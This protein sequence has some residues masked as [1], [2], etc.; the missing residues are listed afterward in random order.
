MRYLPLIL[1]ACL[2]G[3]QSETVETPKEATATSDAAIEEAV[4]SSSL[5][6]LLDAQPDEVNV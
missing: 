4:E 1:A 5:A 2:V 6:A 3:C